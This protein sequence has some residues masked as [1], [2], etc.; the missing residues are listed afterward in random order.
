MGPSGGMWGPTKKRGWQMVRKS[1]EPRF[2]IYA[3]WTSEKNKI[4]ALKRADLLPRANAL[5]FDGKGRSEWTNA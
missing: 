5:S 3:Y 2:M 1:T 4:A